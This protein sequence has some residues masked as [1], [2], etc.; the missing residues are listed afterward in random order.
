[1]RGDPL[2]PRFLRFYALYL[3][4][5]VCLQCQLNTAPRLL[6]SKSPVRVC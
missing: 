6:G 2:R 5:S 4:L 1:M 3:R